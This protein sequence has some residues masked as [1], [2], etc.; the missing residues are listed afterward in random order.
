[1][2]AKIKMVVLEKII[3]F[4]VGNM[5]KKL[6]VGSLLVAEY[7]PS[8]CMIYC[9]RFNRIYIIMSYNIAYHILTACRTIIWIFR[10]FFIKTKDQ[11]DFVRFLLW[12]ENW[13]FDFFPF[14]N[15]ASNMK[16]ESI[17]KPIKVIFNVNESVKKEKKDRKIMNVV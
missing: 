5:K 14:R 11:K 16:N 4:Y 17:T 3:S 10:F 7:Y 2:W 15:F 12:L 9:L 13:S 8:Y 1:M 6:H